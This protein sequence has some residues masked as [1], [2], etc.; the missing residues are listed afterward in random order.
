MVQLRV[1]GEGAGH[2]VSRRADPGQPAT[3]HGGA[4]QPNSC[5]SGHVTQHVQAAAGQVC[6]SS[7]RSQRGFKD[8]TA[9]ELVTAV[10]VVAAGDAL[11]AR[12]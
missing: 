11:L 1:E 2:Q 6:A 10:R 3:E 8:A 12:R 5:H 4:Q 9:A 7:G